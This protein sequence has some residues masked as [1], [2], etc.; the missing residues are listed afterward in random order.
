MAEAVTGRRYERLLAREIYRPLGLAETS[1]PRTVRMPRPYLHGYDVAPNQGA[2][3]VSE[4]INP[5]GAW[6]S[7]GIVSM[8]LEVA[9]FFRAYVAGRFF[10]AAIRRQQLRFRPGNSSPPGPDATR[11]G[12]LYSATALAAAPSTATPAPSRAT[13]CSPLPAATDAAPSSSPSTPK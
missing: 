2:E 3:D 11:Q 13:G 9:R 6:A 7:G 5:A 8:P 1:L 12:W 4:L 10:G